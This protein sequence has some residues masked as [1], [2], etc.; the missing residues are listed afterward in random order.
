MC[1]LLEPCTFQDRASTTIKKKITHFKVIRI[2]MPSCTQKALLGAQSSESIMDDSLSRTSNG[3]FCIINKWASFYLSSERSLNTAG[4]PFLYL[5]VHL[6]A[7]QLF[8][9]QTGRIDPEKAKCR[10]LS[11]TGTARASFLW[12]FLTVPPKLTYTKTKHCFPEDGFYRVVLRVVTL[13]G[14]AT[15]L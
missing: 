1:R 10:E 5:C 9:L 15:L 11:V 6:R 12:S 3:F 2:D 4:T 8:V 14:N 7:K 13:C